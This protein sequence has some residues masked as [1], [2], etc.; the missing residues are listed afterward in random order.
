M[1]L[2]RTFGDIGVV[3]SP[4]LSGMLADAV[5]IPFTIGVNAAF[6]GVAA[7]SFLVFAESSG[8]Q[9]DRSPS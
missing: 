7:L 4:V 1:G 3:L 2:Y 5:S 8:P 9:D 6:M